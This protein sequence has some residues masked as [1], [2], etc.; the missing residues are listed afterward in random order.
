M[1]KLFFLFFFASIV[2]GEVFRIE[3]PPYQI[4]DNLI[5]EVRPQEVQPQEVQ[6][7]IDGFGLILIPG[8]P[9]LPCKL[10]W[11]AIPPGSKITNCEIKRD[12]YPVSN[13]CLII[14]TPHELKEG[15][16]PISGTEVYSRLKWDTGDKPSCYRL[17]E[18]Y[19]SIAGKYLGTCGFRGYNLVK[20]AIFPFAYNPVT[21]S[22]YYSPMVTINL[23]WTPPIIPGLLDTT[24]DE[25]LEDFMINFKKTKEWYKGAQAPVYDYVIITSPILIPTVKDFADWKESLGY[26]VKIIAH[27]QIEAVREWNP[28]YIL[29]IGESTEDFDDAIVGRIP[30]TESELIASILNHTI[31]FE[32]NR[33]KKK[34]LFVKGIS[35]YDNEDSSGIKM[36]DKSILLEDL[37]SLVS[38][39]WYYEESGKEEIFGKYSII[40]FLSSGK[41]WL[42][43]DGDKIPES[44]EIKLSNFILHNE[45][46]YLVFSPFPGAK[47]LEQGA[48]CVI[49]PDS[50]SQYILGWG[51]PLSGGN[52]SFNY[53]FFKYLLSSPTVGTAFTR[54]KFWYE[55]HFPQDI[56]NINAFKIFGD[57][58]LS[59]ERIP[60][61]DAG[62]SSDHVIWLPPER[63]FSPSCWVHNSGRDMVLN[64]KLY[65]EID[66]SGIPIYSHYL[67]ID[68]LFAHEEQIIKFPELSAQG[69]EYGVRFELFLPNDE[70]PDNDTFLS[71]ARVASGDFLVI[72]TVGILNSTLCELGYK[73]VWSYELPPLYPW[74]QNFRAIFISLE[75]AELN[76][77]HYEVDSLI[78]FLKM[79]GN[80]YV[81][82][83]N[84]WLNK[85]LAGKKEGE[86]WF[87]PDDAHPVSK[88]SINQITAFYYKDGF[89]IWCSKFKLSETPLSVSLI[90]SVM[91]FFEIKKPT[92]NQPPTNSLG[93]ESNLLL[94]PSLPN[95]FHK[96]TIIRFQIQRMPSKINLSVYNLAGKSVKNLFT[97]Y[98][99]PG[100]Y[101]VAWDTRDESGNPVVNG[102]Y[103]LR[104]Q[105]DNESHLGKL[106]SLK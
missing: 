60:G 12:L 11:I 65:C 96:Q 36:E 44:N 56:K 37:E 84:L 69:Q 5:E 18:L 40:N 105:G 53:A 72:D 29:V 42:W 85:L 41:H 6:P 81:E 45:T 73:G 20:V 97:G 3:T 104:L 31:E 32:I 67:M 50:F 88:D 43:D 99:T 28:K 92:I 54:A 33:T 1:V 61:I 106:I 87:V 102:V 76:L 14:P 46:P 51:N 86:E 26:R 8:K 94:L 64:C 19:P 13:S 101:E 80:L 52:Q 30:Y 10:V 25:F 77:R 16:S 78:G 90:D 100:E 23:N 89:K 17:N 83:N 82:G 27:S 34:I 7:Q 2:N 39:N 91:H 93:Q 48:I 24:L 49:S 75:D 57:P 38:T 98:L 79:G 74:L 55:T 15:G 63:S 4:K 71:V 70:N 59:L 9:S 47:F 95:P 22:L 103:F 68:T 62:I 21:L 35:N 66:S 58:S